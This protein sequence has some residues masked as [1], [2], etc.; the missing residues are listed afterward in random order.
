MQVEFAKPQ[1]RRCFESQQT[2]LGAWPEAI[3]KRYI[4]TIKLMYSAKSLGDL[5]RLPSLRLEK[6]QG[7]KK[8]VWSMRLN[9]GWRLTFTVVK[10]DGVEILMV[11]EVSNHYGD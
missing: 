10:V 11:R 7:E 3:A 6:L 9:R 5:A 8:G 1:L 4:M 2:A